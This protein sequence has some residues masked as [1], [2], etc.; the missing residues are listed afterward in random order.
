MLNA[1]RGFD[2]E[3]VLTAR[4]VLPDASFTP[5]RRAVFID[6]LLERLQGPPAV[7]AA[8]VTTVLPLGT[9]DALMGFRMPSRDGSGDPVQV[10]TALREVSPDYFS[11]LGLR[12]VQGRA[13]A[14]SDTMTSLPV[15]LVN[16]TFANRYLG[17]D[18]VG[19]RIPVGLDDA[20]PEWEIVGV[21]EDVLTRSVTDPPQ[22]E[23]FVSYRQLS[24]VHSDPFLVVRTRSNAAA[25]TASIRSMISAE[26]PSAALDQIM[27]M[28]QR[29][30]SS[31]TQPRLF[32]VVLGGLRSSPS[33]SPASVCLVFSLT[34]SAS[35]LASSGFARRWALAHSTS[36]AS[37]S[38]RGSS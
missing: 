15:I 17:G 36:P 11:A 13:L 20:R 33:R 1:D 8:G 12:I 14:S 29:V 6:R 37:S 30:M 16:R 34:S 24:V 23:M 28:E 7:V 9:G 35:D 27:T 5:Q 22:P 38:A 2:P 3:N 25:A 18:P 21:V 19:R 26:D 31:L 10:Q 4:V 32:A